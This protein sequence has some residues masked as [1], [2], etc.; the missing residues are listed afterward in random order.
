MI[1]DFDKARSCCVICGKVLYPSPLWAYKTVLRGKNM[2]ACSYS[3]FRE[4]QSEI[5]KYGIGSKDRGI[6]K[7][8]VEIDKK[9]KLLNRWKSCSEAA[10]AIGMIPSALADSTRKRKVYE[11]DGRYFSRESVWL[12]D[13][14]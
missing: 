6:R 11:N 9:G 1:D 4:M 3:H 10:R 5:S 2:Y 8:I 14:D 7:A 13:E 12:D